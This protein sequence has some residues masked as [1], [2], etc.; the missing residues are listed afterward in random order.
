MVNGSAAN[1]S[2]AFNVIAGGTLTLGG[3]QSSLITGTVNIGNAL[4]NAATDGWDGI[5]CG[6]DFASLG[7]TINDVALVKQNS[8]VI[9]GQEAQDLV[10]QDFATVSLTSAPVI[11]TA[12]AAAGF[13]QCNAKPDAQ[14]GSSAIGITGPATVTFNNGTIQCISGTAIGLQTSEFANGAPTLNMD[15][16]TI[17]NTALGIYASGGTATVT[18]T[19]I[20]YNFIGVQQDHDS[21]NSIDGTIDL[22][23]GGNTVI[24][25]SNQE[26]GSGNEGIDVYNTSQSNLAADNV[27][28]DTTSPDYFSCD[29]DSS[30]ATCTCLIASCTRWHPS[31][32]WTPS[33]TPPTWA[34]SPRPATRSPQASVTEP[35]GSSLTARWLRLPR[36]SF[37]RKLGACRRQF[38]V[39]NGEL[40]SHPLS[41]L[42]RACRLAAAP[43]YPRCA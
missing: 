18:N 28:W 41:S 27:A 30:T 6:S 35:H 23:G 14:N 9:Q 40:P 34:A 43:W 19:T 16:V 36:R 8:V 13:N 11:G 5:L 42:P 15:T 17:Q 39:S 38:D 21:V 26:T 4:N 25:S 12:P 3:D 37:A 33:R 29:S 22:T 2:A 20:N 31:T 32:T 7:C 10:I 24:C 1:G